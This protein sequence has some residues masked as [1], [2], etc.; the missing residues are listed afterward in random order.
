LCKFNL[1]L[2]KSQF[3]L[4]KILKM[5]T[6]NSDPA[7]RAER[8]KKARLM[9]GLKRDAFAKLAGV[10]PTTVSYWENVTHGGLT[11]DG[12]QKTVKALEAAGLICTTAW[13]LFGFEEHPYYKGQVAQGQVVQK[14]SD[15]INQRI[16][17]SQ[18]EMEDEINLFK[19]RNNSIVLQIKD[20]SMYPFFEE[21]DIVGGIWQDINNINIADH[22]IFIVDIN[23]NLLVKKIEKG[24]SYKK[25]NLYSTCINSVAEPYLIKNVEIV[26]VASIIRFWRYS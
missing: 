16:I 6:I 3:V 15:S 2:I 11:E 9:A 20:N 5:V 12:A 14:S 18:I 4:N 22:M 26:K 21:K 13:L 8:L 10:S 1:H 25:Y 7:A 19:N 17:S 24:S 23:N